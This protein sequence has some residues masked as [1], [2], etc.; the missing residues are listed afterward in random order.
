MKFVPTRILFL[1]TALSFSSSYAQEGPM[2]PPPTPPPPGTPIDGY[3]F[4]L[5]VVGI[6]FAFF[7]FRKMQFK[8]SV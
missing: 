6:G 3:V 2:P 7:T 4:V 1:L 5:A 8:K